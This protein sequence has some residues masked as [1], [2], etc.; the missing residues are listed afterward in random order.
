MYKASE[1]FD[2]ALRLVRDKQFPYHPNFI[3]I[4]QT[5]KESNKLSL[6]DFWKKDFSKREQYDKRYKKLF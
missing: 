6:I 3:I 1:I 2:K 4:F 5:F